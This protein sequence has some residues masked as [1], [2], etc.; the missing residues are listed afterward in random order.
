MRAW[1]IGGLALL[2]GACSTPMLTSVDLTTSADPVLAAYGVGITEI[3]V[4]AAPAGG[5]GWL[6]EPCKT[7]LDAYDT[8]RVA[9]EAQLGPYFRAATRIMHG[10]EVLDET[11]NRALTSLEKRSFLAEAKALMSLG[12]ILGTLQAAADRAQWRVR[13]RCP[14]EHALQLEALAHVRSSSSLLFGLELQGGVLSDDALKIEAGTDGLLTSVSATADDQSG[15][16]IVNVA[17]LIGRLTAPFPPAPPPPPSGTESLV[18]MRSAAADRCRLSALSAAARLAEMEKRL[19]CVDLD[20]LK[21]LV[22]DLAIQPRTYPDYRPDDPPP[23]RYSLSELKAGVEY[24]GVSLVA[25]CVEPSPLIRTA[26]MEGLVVATPTP[27]QLFALESPDG[28]ITQ[29]FSF[30]GM[31]EE[32]LMVVPVDRAD[33]VKNTTSLAFRDG[34][35]ATVEVSRPSQ[36][37]AALGLPARM[38]NGLVSGVTQAFKD[39]EA[40]EEARVAQME[41]ETARI[42]AEAGRI[43]QPDPAWNAADTQ[44]IEAIGR[45]DARRAEYERELS[46][47]EPDTVKIAEASAALRN[48]QAAAN[49]SAQ[50]AGR[51]LPYPDL[52]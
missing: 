23:A 40:I 8:A 4:K 24:E 5:G 44:Y 47:E 13:E 39:S 2:C 36:G 43:V 32:H 17:T 1:I 12:E 26:R 10:L 45:V 38:I 15:A 52:L 33:L 30:I 16:A 42:S 21:I 49:A 41:A 19:T 14:V 6:A 29:R 34:M 3:E 7:A 46:A 25:D 48:A 28:P 20:G 11:P 50:Q 51:P 22:A 31:S 35:V 37:A 18:R 27:C 9:H